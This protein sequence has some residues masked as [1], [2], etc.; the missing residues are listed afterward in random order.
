MS[1]WLSAAR[2]SASPAASSARARSPRVR[3]MNSV[4]ASIWS[5]APGC[6]PRRRRLQGATGVALR[7]ARGPESARGVTMWLSALYTALSAAMR[8]NSTRMY[9][10]PPSVSCWIARLPRSG[11]GRSS[12]SSTPRWSVTADGRGRLQRLRT[13]RRAPGGNAPL[14]AAGLEVRRQADRRDPGRAHAREHLDRLFHAA[15]TV[16]DTREADG[17]G[18]RS[19]NRG[20][21]PPHAAPRKRRAPQGP[22]RRELRA[23][24]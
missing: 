21:I 5:S 16:V 13:P 8:V 18:D 12:I 7:D 19:R 10:V 23:P 4:L 15:G 20:A 6:L 22:P 1:P 9:R 2:M 17:N 3:G 11:K 24:G 14:R